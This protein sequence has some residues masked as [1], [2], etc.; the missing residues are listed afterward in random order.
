MLFGRSL[1][2][3]ALYP[4]QVTAAGAVACSATT[5][6]K[7]TAAF[8]DASSSFATATVATG[9]GVRNVLPVAVVPQGVAT[10]PAA[11]A[12]V[13]FSAAVTSVGAASVAGRGIADYLLGGEGL[14]EALPSGKVVRTTKA[15]IPSNAK[16][17]AEIEPDAAIYA[18]ADPEAVWC[19]ANPF[20]TYWYVGYGA[21][22]CI[23]TLVGASEQ[24]LVGAGQC[25]T[26]T[27]A[28][29]TARCDSNSGGALE[30]VA[31]ADSDPLTTIQGVRNWSVRGECLAEGDAQASEYVFTVALSVGLAY[32][33]AA[34]QVRRAA[35]GGAYTVAQASGRLEIVLPEYSYVLIESQAGGEATAHLAAFATAR[36]GAEGAS[37]AAASTEAHAAGVAAATAAPANNVVW[38]TGSGASHGECSAAAVVDRRVQV[39]GECAQ[40]AAATAV[41]RKQAAALGSSTGLA[42]AAAAGALQPKI[43]VAGVAV[44]MAT[45]TGF[46]RI[47]DASQRL[48]ARVVNVSGA[49]RTLTLSE[50]PRLVVVGGVS[51][52]LA[53]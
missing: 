17:F 28:S 4:R 39:Q 38:L 31:S 8:R 10:V 32:P 30:A 22:D 37:A 40:A 15:L 26:E 5:S 2:G 33:M 43:P 13:D 6:A 52:R 29:G 21:A 50:P 23:A 42:A 14:G 18:L 44:A 48:S 9:T 46:N 24:I 1:F 12:K 36:V 35:G 27:L 20:G 45:V 3:G 16:C 41:G 53:A 25:S 34:A 19:Y 11:A 7:A 49:S 47:N 51:R